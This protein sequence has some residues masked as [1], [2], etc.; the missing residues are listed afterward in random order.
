MGK[1]KPTHEI[2]LGRIRATIW[3][4]VSDDDELWFNVTISRIYKSGT[5]WKDSSSFRRDDLPIVMKAL[6]MAHSWIWQAQLKKER[7]DL[8]GNNQ[9]A[10]KTDR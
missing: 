5:T 4:N 1:K 10:Q 6:D 3:S 9:V 8:K 2:K 7:A